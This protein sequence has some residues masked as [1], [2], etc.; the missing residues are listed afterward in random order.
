MP[1][2][3]C[4]ICDKTFYAKPSWLQKG[5]SK[6]CSRQCQFEG[7][8]K[9]KEVSCFT[10][11][12]QVYKSPRELRKSKSK[13]YFCAKSCQTIWRNSIVYIGPN[14][15]NWRG[16]ESTCK[17]YLIKSKVSRICKLCKVKDSRI[18]AVH[19]VDRNRKNNKL[20]NLIWLCH[21]C[22]FLV[23]HFQKEKEKFME[24]LV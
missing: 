3:E 13:K 23:H 14:H 15:S 11:G 24:V 4:K 10:C 17:N 19:H 16:G 20:E 18:L 22:H 8:K 21:N 12:K 6:Y 9:G 7:Q 5:W 1:Q 2:V